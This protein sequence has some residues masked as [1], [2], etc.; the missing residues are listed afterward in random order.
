MLIPVYI[1]DVKWNDKNTNPARF[2]YIKCAKCISYMKN[3]VFLLIGTTVTLLLEQ[4]RVCHF[5]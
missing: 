4:P 2:L 3:E 5:L 1:S